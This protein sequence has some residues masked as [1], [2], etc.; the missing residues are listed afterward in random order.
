MTGRIA[1]TSIDGTPIS[2]S[3]V[4]RMK[5]EEQM[6]AEWQRRTVRVVAGAS[7]D[8]DDCR[9]LL[10]ILGLGGPLV[11]EARGEISHPKAARKRSAHAA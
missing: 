1:A 10:D 3:D 5:A 2:E 6:H 11:A 8:A 7:R 9:L 4:A